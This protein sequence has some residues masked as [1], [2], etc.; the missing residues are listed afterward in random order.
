MTPQL[1]EELAD[2]ARR[3]ADSILDQYAWPPRPPMTGDES[4]EYDRLITISKACWYR[5]LLAS[6]E[7][8]NGGAQ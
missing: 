4:R 1:W 2:V 3:D 8:S 6:C 5:S 7:S